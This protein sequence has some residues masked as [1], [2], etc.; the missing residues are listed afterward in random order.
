L[1]VS[2]CEQTTTENQRRELEEVAKRSSWEIAGIYKDAGIS[3][4]KGREKGPDFDRLCNKGLLRLTNDPAT[5]FSSSSETRSPSF[6]RPKISGMVQPVLNPEYA[7]AGSC[8]K[9]SSSPTSRRA[10]SRRV[11]T[12]KVRTSGRRYPS[13]C[14]FGV[15]VFALLFVHVRSCAPRRFH[16]REHN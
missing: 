10:R 14:K 4:A 6:S 1:R 15:P 11:V 8:R 3:G 16:R 13:E 5:Q 2:A 12:S 9:R 7:N